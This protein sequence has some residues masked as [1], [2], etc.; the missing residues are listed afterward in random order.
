[1][2]TRACVS[3]RISD[4]SG[5]LKD[6]VPFPEPVHPAV[7]ASIVLGSVSQVS[8][9]ILGGTNLRR[10]KC[11]VCLVRQWI[12]VLRQSFLSLEEY[13]TIFHVNMDLGF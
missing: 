12:H 7:Y 11:S 8:V 4:V 6:F 9:F 10:N 3:F 5:L 13:P 1:M 2:D